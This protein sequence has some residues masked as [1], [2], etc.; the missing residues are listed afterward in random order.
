MNSSFK[1][2][3]VCRTI[4][5]YTSDTYREPISDSDCDTNQQYVYNYSISIP[6]EIWNR[7]NGFYVRSLYT[8]AIKGLGTPVRNAVSLRSW[9][10]AYDAPDIFR[11]V[12]SF[13]TFIIL[14][15]AR[16]RS[17]RT[18]KVR[19]STCVLVMFNI[20]FAV[21]PSS[22]GSRDANESATFGVYYA[23]YTH[24][25]EIGYRHQL[26]VTR[27]HTGDTRFYYLILYDKPLLLL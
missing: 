11:L 4:Y 2:L 13:I 18:T 21:Q 3:Y 15:S 5:N 24:I 26:T 6:I 22:R 14:Y 7:F 9:Y 12:V 10:Y 25:Q 27:Y 23:L 17:D 20:I 1:K 16:V 8:G 19:S